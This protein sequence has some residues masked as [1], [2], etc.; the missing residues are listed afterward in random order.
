MVSAV[1]PFPMGGSA[2][3]PCA[4]PNM[5]PFPKEGG[6]LKLNPYGL[7][8]TTGFLAG[9]AALPL[10]SPVIPHPSSRSGPAS[11]HRYR[12]VVGVIHVHSHYSDGR[13]P[14]ESIAKI[15][16]TQELDF[17]IFTDH[18]TLQGRR[19]G[20]AGWYGR[21]LVLIDE[22]I[23]T[24]GGHYLGLRLLQEVPRKQDARWTMEAVSAQGG[25]GFVAHPFWKRRLWKEPEV[26]EITGL[27]IYS[28]VEDV[29]EENLLKL[30]LWT[31]LTGSEFSLIQWLDRPSESLAWW[32]R[33]LKE[34]DR[35]VGIGSPDAHGLRR[36]GLRLGPYA[37][38]FKLVRNHLLVP[39]ISKEALYEALTKGHLFVA[40]DLVADAKGFVFLA[41]RRGSVEGVLGDQV[42]AQPDLRLYVYLPS[43]GTV[44]F[45]KDGEKIAEAEGQ[46]GWLESV[47]PGVY[48]VEAT[49][50]GRPWIYSN[51]IYV[52]E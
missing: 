31:I 43:R 45:L 4:R 37:T 19:E 47:T 32:D 49:R 6:V 20:K 27:E 1:E 44:I 41:S 9:C 34:G 28:A 30:A 15:A 25:L 3:L 14:V 39:E 2:V 42:K 52:I 22:E 5:P 7:I 50:E 11:G 8:L 46:H 24:N 40:H 21:T 26:R 13:L 51:P 17:L 48:R 16:R 33:M 29:T 36:F 10:E 23:S 35:V 18:D 12:E 38:M